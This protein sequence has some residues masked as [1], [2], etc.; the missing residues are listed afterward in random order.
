MIRLTYW[1]I[2]S[3]MLFTNYGRCILTGKRGKMKGCKWELEHLSSVL[4]TADDHFD[5]LI[6][7]YSPP[8]RLIGA[9]SQKQV[10]GILHAKSVGL[11]SY[12]KSS[13]NLEFIKY[14]IT[15]QVNCLA[16]LESIAKTNILAS[17]AYSNN[18]YHVEIWVTDARIR[19]WVVC[20]WTVAH[21]LRN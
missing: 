17:L 3:P 18:R 11:S 7:L 21:F 6:H 19:L 4:R 20:V 9:I 14:Q 5:F 10:L 8:L 1:V 15:K 16:N 2:V 13:Q 12:N